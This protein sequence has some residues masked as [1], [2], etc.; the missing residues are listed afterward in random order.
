MSYASVKVFYMCN[1]FLNMTIPA[2]SLSVYYDVDAI[3]ADVV[4]QYGF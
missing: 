2:T 1:P 4:I 3:D